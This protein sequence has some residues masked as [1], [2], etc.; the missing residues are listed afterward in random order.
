MCYC[1]SHVKQI[2]QEVFGTVDFAI[3]NKGAKQYVSG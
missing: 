1:E 2:S 3:I